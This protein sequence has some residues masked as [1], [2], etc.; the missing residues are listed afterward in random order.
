MSG[1][2]RVR[3]YK[4]LIVWQKSLDLA[5]ICHDI[6]AALPRGERGDLASQIRKSSSSVPANTAEGH[7]RPGRGEFLSFLG[8]AHGSLKELE[9]HLL[10]LERLRHGSAKLSRALS[11]TQE[12][13][14]M[15]ATLRRRLAERDADAPTPNAKR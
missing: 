7:S 4:D 8:I 9:C 14:R 6:V 3:D 10:L 1:P 12:C 15:L 5:A 2:A 13:S 11:L